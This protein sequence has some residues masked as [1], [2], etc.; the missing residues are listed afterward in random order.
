LKNHLKNGD[1]IIILVKHVSKLLGNQYILMTT[2][3]ATK[4]VESRAFHTNIV[5]ITAKCLYE[6][7]LTRFGC[8][9][10]I[11]TN[12]STHFINDAIKYL[13]DHFMLKHTNYII[14]YPQ[15]NGQAKSRNKKFGTL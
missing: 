7:I 1:L 11:V 5:A 13:T 9:L 2:D 15:G 10:T 6:Y 3:Y 8:P 14:Y 4:W 12:Q